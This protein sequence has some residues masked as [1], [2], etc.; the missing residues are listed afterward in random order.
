MKIGVSVRRGP[1]CPTQKPCSASASPAPGSREDLF[2]AKQLRIGKLMDV[3]GV[4]LE[5]IRN[6]VVPELH[7]CNMWSEG[8]DLGSK[9][10][11]D[12]C[13]GAHRFPRFGFACAK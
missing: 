5:E 12:A 3:K 11:L 4:K 13:I 9:G 1:F 7:L 8:S 6:I 10:R 2:L